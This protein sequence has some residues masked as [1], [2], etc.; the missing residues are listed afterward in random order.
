MLA[1]RS[2]LSPTDFSEPS[3][4]AYELA[5]SLAR[6][7]G[8]ELVVCHVVDLPLLMP[9]EGMLIPTPMD[10]MEK[11]REELEQSHPSH[12]G[13]TVHHRLVEGLPAEE[14]LRIATEVKPDLIVM[15]THGRGGL[16]RLVMGSVAE[17]VMRK[18]SC[19]VLTVKTPLPAEK[20]PEQALQTATP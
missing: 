15:G 11:V 12:S 5:C 4:A 9:A 17:K 6:D 10:E 14:I 20:K 16:S 8:A 2:I 19:P 13:V 3:R 7:Y 18:A 1:I